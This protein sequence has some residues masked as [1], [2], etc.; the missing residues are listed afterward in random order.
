MPPRLALSTFF[1]LFIFNGYDD[2]TV[3]A[4]SDV[5]M[6]VHHIAIGSTHLS[7]QTFVLGTLTILSPSYLNTLSM[8]VLVNLCTGAHGEQRHWS[9]WNWSY[10][11]L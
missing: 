4:E 1:S 5:S 2:F 7:L 10:R 8:C 3:R 11:R 6:H 9:P